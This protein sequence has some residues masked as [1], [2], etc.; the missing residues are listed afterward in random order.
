MPKP[1]VTQPATPRVVARGIAIPA[2]SIV[3]TNSPD[4]YAASPL[5]DGLTINTETGVITGTPIAEGLV[6]TSITATNAD[7]ES[8]AVELVWVVQAYPVG[9]GNWSDLEID[10]DFHTRKV[11]IPGVETGKDGAVFRV[12][13]GDY[14]Y[15]LVGVKKYGV[16]QDLKPSSQTVTVRCALKEFEPESIV[17]LN[18]GTPTTKVGSNDTTRFRIPIQFTPE[19]WQATLSNYEDD[20]KTSVLAN[21]EIEVTV[22]TLR[23]TTVPFKVEVIRDQVPD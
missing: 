13:K 14:F 17:E 5:P 3:A 12:G 8:D 23:I 20:N 9:S 1:V 7:G 22:N 4:E 19:K 15:L 10:I 21:T 6:T 2:L 11:S 16:L 18:D